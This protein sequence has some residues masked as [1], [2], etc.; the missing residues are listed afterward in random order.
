MM[1]RLY[2][3]KCNVCGNVV[4]IMSVGGGTL[5]CCGEDMQYM[6]EKSADSST[7]K[8]VPII[9]PIDEGV[10]VTVGST[11]HPMTDEHYIQWI[12]VING[13][14]VNRKYLAPGQKPQAEFY[15][16][17]SDTLV[18]REFCNVHGHWKNK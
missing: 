18:A 11:E 17:F 1:K 7:E 13:D 6:E 8:H 10:R 15:V 2:V 14:W 4:E 3:Y 5:S 12:E 9:E 16:P